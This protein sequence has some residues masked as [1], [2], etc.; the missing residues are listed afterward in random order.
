MRLRLPRSVLCLLTP[1]TLVAVSSPALGQNTGAA[2]GGLYAGMGTTG[3]VVGYGQTYSPV[4]GS[5]LE[6]AGWSNIN[7]NLTEGGID[8]R[9]SLRMRRAGAALDWHPFANGFRLSAGLSWVDTQVNLNA[10]ALPGTL[11][12]VGNAPA[13]PLDAADGLTAR[14][15]LPRTMPYLGLGWGQG[16]ARGWTAH[17][18]LGA[19]LGKAKVTGSLTPSL[20]A[21]IAAAGAGI[22]P[23]VELDREL[24]Q[25][26]DG[27]DKASFYPVLQLGVSYRW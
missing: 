14:V 9:G 24:Q 7:R 12:A 13:V 18:D 10:N 21:K 2:G 16:F 1:L 25:V 20:R 27:V 4:F 26:R 11:I 5:R 15:E 8:Y 3:L 6:A 19:L 23:D 17:A 22:D